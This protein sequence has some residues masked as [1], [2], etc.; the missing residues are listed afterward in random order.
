[1]IT[2]TRKISNAIP[3]PIPDIE[4]HGILVTD[5]T[6]NL[7]LKLLLKQFKDV[8]EIAENLD[9]FISLT[10][11][12][13]DRLRDVLLDDDGSQ[14]FCD[15][16]VGADGVNSP[17]TF[18]NANV[19]VPKHLMERLIKVH[20]NKQDKYNSDEIYYRATIAFFYPSELDNDKTEN[21]KVNDNDS[22][23][24]IEHVKYIIQKLRPE[25]EMIEILLELWDLDPKMTP[26]D[27]VKYPFKT[28]NPIQQRK[29][30][31]IN[32]LFVNSWTT[33]AV[34][35]AN[36][37][38]QAL[39]NYTPENSISCIKE[40][41]NEMLKRAS[42]DVLNSRDV[43]L[44]QLTK[45]GY[46]GFINRNIGADGVNSPATFVNA[47]VAVPKHLM[48]RLIKV[49]GNKQDKYNSDEIYYRATIAFFYPSEL[50]NDKTENFKV[51][52]NDS[53]SVIEHVK[54]IIQKLRPECEMIEI[55]LELWDLDPKM[56]PNDPVKYPFKT[57]NPIQQRKVKDINPLFVNSWTTNA[58]QDAN[59]L[60]QALFNYTPE[61]SISCIKEYEN[62]MLKRASADVL[63][64]RDV[65]LKQLTKVGYFGFINRNSIL[66][67]TNLIMNNHDLL[68]NF[69][70]SIYLI[71]KKV[72]NP[73]RLD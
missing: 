49:H 62:E 52:D 66:K 44:K 41:E 12:Y 59:I 54:Y 38:S 5:Y 28:Y 17:A 25:C 68:A 10:V 31:D 9:H 65:I 16:L 48:E 8:Y 7:L 56:T 21:F 33:N 4:Y 36:I 27:P 60:S 67:I 70:K 47:N 24:V 63:N 35:D 2:A 57:Y 39:F 22:A 26:N 14:E 40:Y 32:P 20:G 61:N 46:F 30:K 51:N 42:A 37:L 43:I 73:L 72:E 45:V 53:A 1:M 50:D 69:M 13:R 55:L 15:I 34:Q 19:A 58:V 29:V 71:K 18:V 23:S 11:A 6:G 3:T 64:S